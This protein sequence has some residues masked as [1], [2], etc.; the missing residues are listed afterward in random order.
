MS[1]PERKVSNPKRFLVA[2]VVA[3]L[4][5]SICCIG[6]ILLL[7]LGIGGA[8]ISS[9]VLFEPYRPIFIGLTLLFLGL[10]F[11]R[12]YIAPRTRDRGSVC[13]DVR[14]LKH[15]RLGVWITAIIALGLIAVPWF[16]P[17]FFSK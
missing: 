13:C 17:L 12:V 7:S 2:G 9:L 16:A 10:A 4:A 14:V 15:W 8:W 5:A 6:P 1:E 11:Y 3:A